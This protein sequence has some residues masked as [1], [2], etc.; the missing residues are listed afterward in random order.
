MKMRKDEDGKSSNDVFGQVILWDSSNLFS[1][2]FIINL[3]A[4]CGNKKLDQQVCQESFCKHIMFRLSNWELQIPL[5]V[6]I[7]ALL[8][9]WLNPAQFR[10]LDRRLLRE[11]KLLFFF[12][13]PFCS[14]KQNMLFQRERLRDKATKNFILDSS[15]YTEFKSS[16]F[17]LVYLAFLYTFSTLLPRAGS[18]VSDTSI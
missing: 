7:L 1:G 12:Q 10:I 6:R 11:M 16:Q 2:F 18:R 5:V 3:N 4:F 17:S 15:K 14:V 13:K 8:L 9:L